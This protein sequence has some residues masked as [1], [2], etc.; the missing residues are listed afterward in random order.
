VT[1]TATKQQPETVPQQVVGEAWLTEMLVEDSREWQAQRLRLLWKRRRFFLRAGARG[2]VASTLVALLIPKS[3]SSIAQ[4]TPPDAQ[5]SSSFA[6][7]AV[8]ASTKGSR[9]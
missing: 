2:L 8:M 9:P 1:Q 4:F 6:M 5:S 3:F 7:M